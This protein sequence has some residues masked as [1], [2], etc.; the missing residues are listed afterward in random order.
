MHRY[1]KIEAF[2]LFVDYVISHT[3]K[4]SDDALHDLIDICTKYHA[5]ERHYIKHC[6]YNY[7]VWS[8]KGKAED[9]A[10]ISPQ[11]MKKELDARHFPKPPSIKEMRKKFRM[12]DAAPSRR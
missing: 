1:Y 4:S 7:I 5:N 12:K 3:E 10:N 8:S 11:I 2:G 9:N 6:V